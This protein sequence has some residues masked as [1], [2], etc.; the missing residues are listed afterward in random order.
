MDDEWTNHRY[1]EYFLKLP[2]SVRRKLKKHAS[3]RDRSLH[4]LGKM[5][6]IKALNKCSAESLLENPMYYDKYGKL[7]F[8]TSTNIDF[9]I[10]HSHNCV[11]CAVIKEGKVGVDVEKIVSLNIHELAFTMTSQ[12]WELIKTN[13]DPTRT[14]FKFW[15]YKESVMKADGRGL[16]IAFEDIHIK[17]N[18]AILNSTEWYIHELPLNDEYCISVTTNRLETNIIAEFVGKNDL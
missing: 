13:T 18:I 2:A 1:N 17:N 5:L 10:S 16:A 12:E 8:E 4:L 9:S 6:L 3:V 14:F 7:R 15:T 11:I